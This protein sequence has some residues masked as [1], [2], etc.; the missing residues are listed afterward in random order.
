MGRESG[1]QRGRELAGGEE[2]CAR[3]PSPSERAR[4]GE[5]D[6]AVTEAEDTGCAEGS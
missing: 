2:G 3:G 1:S 4:P 6:S 5:E